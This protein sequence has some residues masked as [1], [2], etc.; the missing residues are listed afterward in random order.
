VFCA[1]SSRCCHGTWLAK[2]FRFSFGWSADEAALY[3]QGVIEIVGGILLLIGAYTRVVA[4][5]GL[6]VTFLLKVTLRK[7]FCFNVL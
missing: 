6:V 7:P 5:I 4:L 3:V 2:I 1:S